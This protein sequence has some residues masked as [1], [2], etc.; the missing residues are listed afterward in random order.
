MANEALVVGI[1]KVKGGQLGV[2][3]I[4]LVWGHTV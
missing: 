3:N 1:W 2:T 4:A